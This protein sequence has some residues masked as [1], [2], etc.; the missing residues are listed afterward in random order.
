MELSNVVHLAEIYMYV[1]V[2]LEQLRAQRFRER[3][4]TKEKGG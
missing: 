4:K 2:V 3:K 1:V